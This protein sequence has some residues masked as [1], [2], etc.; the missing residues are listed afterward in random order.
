MNNF[1]P[2]SWF[3][4]V[5]FNGLLHIAAAIVVVLA[6]RWLAK[7]SRS[8][9]RRALVKAELTE[10]LVTLFVNITY[11]T[12]MLLAIVAALTIIGVPTTSI[13]TILAVVLVILGIALQESLSN[14]AATVIFLLF[15]PFEVGDLIEGGHTFGIVK[16]VQLF[17]TVI[18]TFDFKTVTVPNAQLYA[19]NIVNYSHLGILRADCDFSI[20]YDDNLLQAKGILEEMLASDE[21]VLPDPPAV[22]VVKELDD[23]SVI[24]SM[25][26]FVK[27]DDYW[28][29]QFEMNERVKL[30]FDEEGITIPFPQQTVHLVQE[31]KR[32]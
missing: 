31:S 18:Q 2:S 6:G 8:L 30:R 32:Q 24:L 15:K 28:N 10:S 23:S 27:L 14:F 16:E 7:R 25:R 26:P 21:R 4:E 3:S 11:Y 19:N 5:S 1:D 12:I 17:N 22:V 29:I 13:V 9:L 20:S